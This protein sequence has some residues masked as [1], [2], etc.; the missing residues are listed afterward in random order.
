M[1]YEIHDSFDYIRLDSLDSHNYVTHDWRYNED[2]SFQFDHKTITLIIP[3]TFVPI[4]HGI[5][6]HGPLNHWFVSGIDE[7]HNEA[8]TT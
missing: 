6:V 3:K 5:M 4:Y 2:H 8:L 1:P 7:T